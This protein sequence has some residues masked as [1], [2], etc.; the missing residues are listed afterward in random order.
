MIDSTKS[1]FENY[2]TIKNTITIAFYRKNLYNRSV[3]FFKCGKNNVKTI[4]LKYKESFEMNRKNKRIIAAAMSLSM[5][6]AATPVSPLYNAIQNAVMM[7][8]SA[9]AYP[10]DDYDFDETTGALTITGTGA[11]S[12]RAFESSYFLQYDK[13]KSVEIGK[14]I[15]G[16]GASAF[17]NCKNIES[18]TFAAGSQLTTIGDSAFNNC[19]NLKNITIPA[20]VTSIGK[21]A[22]HC[23]NLESIT[24]AEGSQLE[25][26]GNEAFDGCNYL[27]EIILPDSVKTIGEY[28]FSYC[29]GIKS[30]TFPDSVVIGNGAF[31]GCSSLKS[32]TF[33][34]FTGTIGEQ[35]FRDCK[36]LESVIFTGAKPNSDA[37]DADAFFAMGT[38]AP[39]KLISAWNADE[40]DIWYKGKFKAIEYNVI[41][42]NYYEFDTNLLWYIDD[43]TLTIE[44]ID[45]NIKDVEMNTV[46]Y[47]DNEFDYAPWYY[48][49]FDNIEIKNGVKGIEQYEFCYLNL[50]SITI[51]ESVDFI[52]RGVFE[53]THFESI[54]FEGGVP[55]SVDGEAFSGMANNVK[56]YYPKEDA[57]WEKFLKDKKETFDWNGGKF[58]A[59][60]YLNW[61]NIYGTGLR[62]AISANGTLYIDKQE[63]TSS[64]N[65]TVPNQ[66]D[67][68][69]W[70]HLINKIKYVNI[71]KDV[72][73]INAEAFS[74]FGGKAIL[75]LEEGYN[76]T[77][78]QAVDGGNYDTFGGGRFIYSQA[79][80]TGASLSLDGKIGVNFFCY[81]KDENPTIII[82]GNEIDIKDCTIKNNVYTYAYWVA[83]KDAYNDIT[84]EVKN[85]SKTIM[86]K[87]SYNVK[88]QY[89]DVI[90]KENANKAYNLVSAL[91]TYINASRAYF[92][93]EKD[94]DKIARLKNEI[95]A[96]Y[97]KTGIP[98]QDTGRINSDN[99]VQYYGTSL[100]LDSGVKLRHYLKIEDINKINKFGLM[101]GGAGLDF[102]SESTTIN[103][104]EYYYIETKEL[105]PKD[106][107]K[108]FDIWY[109]GTSG[110]GNGLVIDDYSVLSYIKL[111]LTNATTKDKELGTICKALYNYYLE[112]IK[113]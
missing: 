35:A 40:S 15:T 74:Y 107:S 25:T 18:V 111:V 49:T 55:E 42:D 10:E 91:D 66:N 53:G 22:F 57:S 104:A 84:I 96:A 110:N 109:Y 30:I 7:Q 112:A 58:T 59:E 52:N 68:T 92:G 4:Y 43:N 28:A 38:S 2:K 81:I 32:I 65:F 16:I 88:S 94:N 82:N 83:P 105:N 98:N 72:K 103:G 61:N 77:M 31:Y 36:H 45:M 102:K 26:I 60:D 97:A 67:N 3:L 95:D 78:P 12:E 56:I 8:A 87:I 48:E 71:S 106:L 86:N 108:Y 13:I 27:T 100:I 99:I 85:G 21:R 79:Q 90:L 37:I 80:L 76:G 64:D 93:I 33:H 5:L 50:K 89:V 75:V 62:W 46:L 11:I 69:P 54:R 14:E 113:Y 19:N 23:Q 34:D 39:V 70:M 47:Y 51:S 29:R 73:D 9:A 1:K 17:N 63:S 24:F 20:S 44:A 41:H 6:A 101:F